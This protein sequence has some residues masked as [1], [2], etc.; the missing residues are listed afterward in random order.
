[1]PADAERRLSA[2]VAAL[3][4]SPWANRDA[5][6]GPPG[7]LLLVG[8]APPARACPAAATARR[9]CEVLHCFFGPSL[10]FAHFSRRAARPGQKD[11]P[12]DDREA[13]RP[14]GSVKGKS[15]AFTLTEGRDTTSSG[16]GGIRFTVTR[17]GAGLACYVSS[18]ASFPLGKIKKSA[19]PNSPVAKKLDNS[20]K[21]LEGEQPRRA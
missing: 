21:I 17:C 9:R 19:S 8:P 10:G 5:G 3:S 4:L 16:W 13:S 11:T 20:S 14:G 7:R 6:P 15:S 2:W 1:M 12:T 18:F